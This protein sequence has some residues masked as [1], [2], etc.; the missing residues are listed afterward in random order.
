[1]SIFKINRLFLKKCF[2]DGAK[3]WISHKINR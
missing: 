1:M 3:E 2:L